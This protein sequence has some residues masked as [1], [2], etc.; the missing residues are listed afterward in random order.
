MSKKPS[1]RTTWY[2]LIAAFGNDFRVE[3]KK[4]VR[5]VSYNNSVASMFEMPAKGAIDFAMNYM[6][7]VKDILDLDYRRELTCVGDILGT[8]FLQLPQSPYMLTM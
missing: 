2:A 3:D 8:P 7:V 4:I 5:L 1:Q 6:G